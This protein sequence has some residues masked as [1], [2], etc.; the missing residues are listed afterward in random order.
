M[1]NE[2]YVEFGG[3]LEFIRA[4]GRCAITGQPFAEGEPMVMV[5]LPQFANW[6]FPVW[7]DFP[8]GVNAKA[9]AVVKQTTL[10]EIGVPLGTIKEAIECDGPTIIYHPVNYTIANAPTETKIV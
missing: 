6:G 8:L 3:Y 5:P 2:Q 10:N 1:G 7:N 9:L 4:N